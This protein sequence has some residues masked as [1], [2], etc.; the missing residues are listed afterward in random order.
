[1]SVGYSFPD[2]VLMESQWVCVR[3]YRSHFVFCVTGLLP[4][5]FLT[6]NERFGSYHWVI[7]LYWAICSLMLIVTNC[8]VVLLGNVRVC[9]RVVP[10][11]RGAGGLGSP[12]RDGEW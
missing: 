1:M 12:D 3:I 6:Q 4:S 9:C 7:I 2:D 11:A 10:G 5:S 8:S